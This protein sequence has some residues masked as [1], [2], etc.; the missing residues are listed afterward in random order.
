MSADEVAESFAM[1]ALATRVLAGTSDALVSIP[2]ATV[3]DLEEAV[4]EEQDRLHPALSEFRQLCEHLLEAS[5]EWQ[6]SHDDYET[7]RPQNVVARALR[8][9]AIDI[10]SEKG[11]LDIDIRVRPEQEPLPELV[12]RHLHGLAVDESATPTLNVSVQPGGTVLIGAGPA[13]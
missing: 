9:P 6:E 8:L 13:L 4:S 12:V 2:R 3:A 10:S 7:R 11:K 5:D 1:L